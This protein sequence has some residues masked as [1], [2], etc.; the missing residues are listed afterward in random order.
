[1]VRRGEWKELDN[2]DVDGRGGVTSPQMA[3]AQALCSVDED[4]MSVLS[5]R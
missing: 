1:M 2:P 5:P 3:R 4:E